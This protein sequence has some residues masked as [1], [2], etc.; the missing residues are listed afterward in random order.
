M[1]FFFYYLLNIDRLNRRVMETYCDV[2]IHLFCCKVF[3]GPM[4]GNIANT[5][6]SYFATAMIIIHICIYM[7]VCVCPMRGGPAGTLFRGQR[8]TE[9]PMTEGSLE[10]LLLKGT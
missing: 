1:M 6:L 4:Q 7:C 5:C 3:N 8:A 9:R 2:L 10:C